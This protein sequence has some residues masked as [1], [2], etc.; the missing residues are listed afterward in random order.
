[1]QNINV[2]NY[3][4][5][6]ILDSACGFENRRFRTFP[7]AVGARGFPHIYIVLSIAFSV[8][9]VKKFRE[10]SAF[11]LHTA[12]TK[13]LAVRPPKGSDLKNKE[14]SDYVFGSTLVVDSPPNPNGIIR[15]EKYLAVSP[16]RGGKTAKYFSCRRA[17]N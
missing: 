3:F 2:D 10:V 7:C 12:T 16:P 1:M 17:I 14:R 13:D 9:E 6:S 5:L 8:G 4:S 15:Q 11:K